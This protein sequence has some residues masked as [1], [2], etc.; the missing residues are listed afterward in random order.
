MSERPA[1]A[2][3]RLFTLGS[4]GVLAAVA[5]LGVA[6]LLR[7]QQ[8]L[9]GNLWGVPVDDAYI[10]FRFAQNLASGHG[11]SFNPN[12]PLPGSTSP[13]WVILLAIPACFGAPL[14]LVAKVY[15]VVFLILCAVLAWRLAARFIDMPSATLAAG[16]LTALDGRL[17]WSAPS[18]MEVTLFAALGLGA[19]LARP[20]T[21]GR[22]VSA[23]PAVRRKERAM[24]TPAMAAAVRTAP[25]SRPQPA[26]VTT[27]LQSPFPTMRLWVASP[28]SQAP[29]SRLLL[30]ALLCGLAT[31]TR[32]EGYLLSAVLAVDLYLRY[33]PSAR[34]VALALALYLALALPYPLFSLLT[35]GHPLPTTFYAK[36]SGLG[37]NTLPGALSYILA[38]IYYVIRSNVALLLAPLGAAVLWR[39]RGEARAVVAWPVLLVIEQALLSPVLYHFGRYVM[40]LEPF[41]CLWAIVGIQRLTRPSSRADAWRATLPSLALLVLAALSVPGWALAYAL[42]VQNINGLQVTLGRWVRHHVPSGVPV[43]THDVGA[44]AYLSNHPVV[45]IVGLVTPRF[46]ALAHEQPASRA[47][48]DIYA[49]IKRQGARYLI[50]FPQVYPDLAAQPGLR[51][52]YS[53][54]IEHAVVVPTDASGTTTM[55]LYKVTG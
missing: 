11:F 19:F 33:R 29:L 18:G 6:F 35:T 43:A 13:L 15:G 44:I 48:R 21:A 31:L 4:A 30:V 40:P 2:S 3:S 42:S 47:A 37:P 20:S 5:L 45:D 51:R 22:P 23:E 1:P 32:P 24:R 28:Q 7:D 49:A 17:L 12:Q 10:H 16:A 38:L 8:A 52:I 53:S 41:F 46:I 34:I 55:V 54:T 26:R 14:W 9:T 25:A 27:R 39:L 36:A 50:I